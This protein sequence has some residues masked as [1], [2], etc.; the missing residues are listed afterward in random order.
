M[1]TRF[2]CC[3]HSSPAEPPAHLAAERPTDETDITRERRDPG[4]RR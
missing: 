1:R 3:C 2:G 4:S